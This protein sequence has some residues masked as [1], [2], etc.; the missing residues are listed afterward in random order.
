MRGKKDIQCVFIRSCV[1]EMQ[2]QRDADL[3]LSCSVSLTLC[4][5]CV[6]YESIYNNTK[7]AGQWVWFL[8]IRAMTVRFPVFRITILCVDKWNVQITKT[9][10]WLQCWWVSKGLVMM[11]ASQLDII[12]LFTEHISMTLTK[13]PSTCFHSHL[14]ICHLNK[15]M[16]IPG[17]E[18]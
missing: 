17:I 6:A 12:T 13:F 5:S 15:W 9:L 1:L 8:I 2:K 7:A 3:F 11:A 18:K 16:S 14:I 4:S 10:Q